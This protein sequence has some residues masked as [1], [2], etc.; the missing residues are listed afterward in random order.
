[1]GL[2][3]IPE[4]NIMI[5]KE[6]DPNLQSPQE[7]NTTKHINFREI[8][9]SEASNTGDRTDNDTSDDSPTKRAWEELRNDNK[10]DQ[11]GNE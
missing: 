4:T 3:N 6:Q 8:E 10:K 5:D 7:A 11:H 9:G 1:M 2:E